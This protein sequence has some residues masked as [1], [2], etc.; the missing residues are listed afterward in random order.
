MVSRAI[1]NLHEVTIN[2]QRFTSVCPSDPKPLPS[3]GV[4]THNLRNKYQNL[5]EKVNEQNAI[6]LIHRGDSLQVR[7]KSLLE[8]HSEDLMV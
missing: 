2:A 6:R 5:F 4:L 8:T 7:I 1:F 3:E